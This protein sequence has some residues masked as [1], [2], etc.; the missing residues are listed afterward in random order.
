MAQYAPCADTRREERPPWISANVAGLA[1]AQDGTR[2]PIGILAGSVKRAVSITEKALGPD[3][4][5]VA[6]SRNNLAELYRTQL[7]ADLAIAPPAAAAAGE[8]R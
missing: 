1:R 4:L 3:A 7:H 2:W 6:Q 8:A 5:P